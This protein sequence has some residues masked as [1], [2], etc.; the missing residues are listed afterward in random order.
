MI[1]LIDSIPSSEFKVG[2]RLEQIGMMLDL[3]EE[4]AIK[5]T[6]IAVVL[7]VSSPLV[8]RTKQRRLRTGVVKPNGPGRTS[9]LSDIFQN[10]LNSSP[11][12][13]ATGVRSQ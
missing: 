2:P 6:D 10:I 5:Q 12:K 7:D 11:R 4:F 8:T 1:E 3:M 13:P 9:E